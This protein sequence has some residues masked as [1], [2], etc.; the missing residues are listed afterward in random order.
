MLFRRLLHYKCGLVTA[1]SELPNGAQP[2]GGNT[3]YLDEMCPLCRM[4]GHHDKRVNGHHSRG[5]H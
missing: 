4:N 2:K 5:V 1:P 3:Y